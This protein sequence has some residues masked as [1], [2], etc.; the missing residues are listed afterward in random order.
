MMETFYTFLQ[1]QESTFWSQY[2]TQIV[3]FVGILISAL[4][5]IILFNKGLK[6]ERE[7]IEK[8][9]QTEKQE[10]VD[11]K[12]SEIA[13]LKS[14][15]RTLVDAT[16]KAVNKQIEEY[17]N[18]AFE[19]M[20]HPYNNLVVATYTHESLKRILLFDSHHIWEVFDENHIVEKHFINLYACLDYFENVF[21]KVQED[22][23]EGNG[24][25]V[26][27]LMNNVIRIRNGILD[28]A[29]NYIYVEKGQNSDYTSNPYWNMLNQTILEYH[30]ENDGIPNIKRDYD[31][32]INKLKPILLS[33]EFKYIPLSNDILKLCKEGGDTYFSILQ[34]NKELAKNIITVAEKV[35]DMN[36]KLGNVL[37]EL[38]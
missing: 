8:Q 25:V 28:L 3:S 6:K 21:K 34:I 13:G 18:K 15:L 36:V 30:Q 9:R 2:G 38:K 12:K 24:Q 14:H 33:E 27:D 37:C 31:L 5:A 4:V 7:R 26:I 16:I 35:Q 1:P 19:I 10:R 17:L 32:L 20:K 29:T 23:Y 22:V 11:Q